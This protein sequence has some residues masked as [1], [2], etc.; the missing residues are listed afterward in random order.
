MG[1]ALFL[2]DRDP[3]GGHLATTASGNI[4]LDGASQRHQRIN[5]NGSNRNVTLPAEETSKGKVFVI[6]NTGTANTLVVKDD[7]ANTICTLAINERGVF[8]C[9]GSVWLG[10]VGAYNTSGN[11]AQNFE[12]GI[13]L[14]GTS[15]SATAAEIDAVA[16]VSARIVNT[17]ATTLS[18]TATQHAGKTVTVNSAAPI[19]I[20][21]PAS[22]GGGNE[23]RFVIGTAATATAHTIKVAN[24]TD[25]LAGVSVIAQTD[26]AQV[27]GFLTTATDDTVSLNGTTKG[28]L[29]G[30]EI[31]IRDIASGVFQV[32]ITGGASGTVVTP[33]SASV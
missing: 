3:W 19:A 4:T 7:A 18:V 23:Y 30:D 5:P 25:I 32:R 12:N 1:R 11:V 8:T 26:T 29:P 14:A 9:N 21:L 6:D 10:E 27:G 31:F 13:K 28:G 15:I 22:T 17:T 33:F 20:T 24:T 2:A 16:D